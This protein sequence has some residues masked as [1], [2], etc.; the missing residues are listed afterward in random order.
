[1]N[2]LEQ[3]KKIVDVILSDAVKIGIIV[4][5]IV[6]LFFAW[7][8]LKNKDTLIK[9][10]KTSNK[11]LSDKVESLVQIN[12]SKVVVTSRDNNGKTIE[13]TVKV[14]VEGNVKVTTMKDGEK[15]DNRNIIDKATTTRVVI[16][17]GTHTTVVDVRHTGFCFFPALSGVYDFD[18]F[19]LGLEA[20]FIFSHSYGIGIGGYKKGGYIFVDRHIEDLIPFAKNTLVGILY[21]SDRRPGL[22]IAVQF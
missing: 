13:T 17:S 7:D 4:V 22:K 9:E 20:R 15:P 2:L 18:D 19:Y 14:P 21:S 12:K 10:L 8:M 1:M 6:A 16:T 5:C 11:V 3:L